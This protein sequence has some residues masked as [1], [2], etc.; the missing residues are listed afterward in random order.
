MN[1]PDFESGQVLANPEEQNEE[2]AS[3]EK[4]EGL[5]LEERFPFLLENLREVIP[6]IMDLLDL[7]ACEVYLGEK[8]KKNLNIVFHAGRMRSIWEAQAAQDES[9]LLVSQYLKREMR[10]INLPNSRVKELNVEL[11]EKAI[12][13]LL[14]LPI[15]S[16]TELFGIA[17]FAHTRRNLL[18]DRELN[19]LQ[20]MIASMAEMVAYEIS[21]QQARVQIIT[22]ERERIGMD[23]HDGIIQSLYGI[24]LS[25]E[26]ARM[27]QAQGKSNGV[28][29]IEKA[30]EALQSAIADIRAYIL[31]L[32]PR[33]LRHANMVEGMRSLIREFRAN[34]M[35]DVTMEAEEKDVEGMARPQIDALYHIFQEAL[36]NTAKHAKATR[37]MVRLWR[38][39][40]RVMLKVSDDGA[41]F[42]TPRPG[43]RIGHGLTNMQARAETAGGGMEVISIRKQGTTL[44]AWVPY[45]K[46]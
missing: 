21:N 39:G 42:D 24:G 6:S 3:A 27:S 45:V 23:L 43:A 33:Q 9:S 35:V 1:N 28:Q 4:L 14:C 44:L 18:T 13:Q 37:V 36:S 20:A 17:C 5:T 25:L 32:R 8:G 2:A 46:E 41:G 16:E 34:T 11:R 29:Q 10:V 26:N 15:Y 40:E 30:L 7:D 31:D 12:G 22:E 19:L 38:Q